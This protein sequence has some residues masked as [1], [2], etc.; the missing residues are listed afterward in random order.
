MVTEDL[1]RAFAFCSEACM[2]QDEVK[3]W[4]VAVRMD[5]EGAGTDIVDVPSLLW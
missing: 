1:V 5:E 4:I 2:R 3:V